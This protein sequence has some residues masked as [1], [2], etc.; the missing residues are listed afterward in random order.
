M[1]RIY[2]APPNDPIQG[3][4]EFHE[5]DR[6]E[7]WVIHRKTA[8]RFDGALLGAAGNKKDRNAFETFE[9]EGAKRERPPAFG[10]AAAL[11]TIPFPF[12]V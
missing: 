7:F 4:E 12:D 2:E 1:H 10:P 5:S 8:R 11:E 6:P 9:P 3:F